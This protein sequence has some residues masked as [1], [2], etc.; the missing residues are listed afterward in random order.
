MCCLPVWRGEEVTSFYI[1]RYLEFHH[2]TTPH[3]FT[4]CCCVVSRVWLWQ[5][6]SS[7]IRWIQRYAAAAVKILPSFAHKKFY[8]RG[9]FICNYSVFWKHWLANFPVIIHIKRIQILTNWPPMDLP[10]WPVPT[11]S[12]VNGQQLLLDCY[13]SIIYIFY[14]II[15]SIL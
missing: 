12:F 11:Q 4:V 7:W 14:S 15:L 5:S 2:C 1:C 13:K 3:S 6:Q 10:P 8:A 9:Y